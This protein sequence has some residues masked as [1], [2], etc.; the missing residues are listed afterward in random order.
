MAV[1]KVIELE[2]D[3]DALQK[4]VSEIQNDFKELKNS[5]SGSVAS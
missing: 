2:I 5:P 4:S 3:V 1:K